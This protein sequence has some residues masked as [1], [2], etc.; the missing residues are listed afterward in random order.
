MRIVGSNV[1]I[2]IDA[3]TVSLEAHTIEDEQDVK[4]RKKWWCRSVDDGRQKLNH[5]ICADWSFPFPSRR[6]RHWE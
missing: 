5:S 2:K 1:L 6:L 4:V 3:P